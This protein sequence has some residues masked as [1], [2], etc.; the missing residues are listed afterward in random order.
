LLTASKLLLCLCAIALSLFGQFGSPYTQSVNG[1][2]SV[3]INAGTHGKQANL[4]IRVLDSNGNIRPSNTY[5]LSIDSS[6]NVSI[7][8]SNSFTGSVKIW[9]GASL[10]SGSGDFQALSDV[11]GN[12]DFFIK[13]CPGCNATNYAARQFSPSGKKYIMAREAKF[14][15]GGMN[16]RDVRIFL[17]NGKL[18]FASSTS[19][20]GS[21]TTSVEGD[22]EVRT[23]V[24][25]FPSGVDKIATIGVGVSGGSYYQTSN[26]DERGF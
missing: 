9:G 24:S 11:E 26:T 15:P 8:W 17:E 6:R 13:V 23:N 25:S 22:C 20:G 18:I 16:G 19:E 4:S 12:G 7:T 10:T 21:C 14:Y 5:T 3:T 2:T 1:S